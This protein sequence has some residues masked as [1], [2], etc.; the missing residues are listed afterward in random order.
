[1][2]FIVTDS[3]FF[4]TIAGVKL[5]VFKRTRRMSMIENLV[6]QIRQFPN[7]GP[8]NQFSYFARDKSRC[9]FSRKQS[10]MRIYKLSGELKHFGIFRFKFALIICEDFI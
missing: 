7:R 4:L 6:S 2:I 3:Y 1:M 10:L 8:G 9:S 5:T